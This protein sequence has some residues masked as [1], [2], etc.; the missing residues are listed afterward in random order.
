MAI[1]KRCINCGAPVS[2][3]GYCTECRL[4]DS[5]LRK[6]QN[7]SVYHYN[8]AL[9]KAK[10]R[11]I[12]GA[13][14][15]LRTSLR[16]DKKNIEARNLLGL[17]YYEIGEMVDALNQ[18]VMSINYQARDNVA[19][20]F[21]KN[22]RDDNKQLGEADNI[23][24]M[25]NT[26]LD[27]AESHSFDLAV[28][29]LRRC[30]SVNKH[31]VKA[32]LLLG[33]I[34]YEQGRVGKAKKTISRVLTI[35]RYNPT[36]IRYLREMGE[37]EGDIVRNKDEA[38]EDDLFDED[39]YGVSAATEDGKRPAKKIEPPERP[40]SGESLLNRRYKRLNR[41]K[42]SN[43]YV[44]VGVIIGIA[45]FYLLIVPVKDKNRKR[46][47]SKIESSYSEKLASKNAETDNLNRELDA[48]QA[49][50]DGYKNSE[51]KLNEDKAGLEKKINDLQQLIAEYKEKLPEENTE[52]TTEEGESTEEGDTENTEEA[53]NEKY[54][55]DGIS[56]T[57]VDQMIDNE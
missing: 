2:T 6:A 44:L 13:I 37:S 19:V 39:Y 4:P 28:I 23:A 56:D 21:L 36:A 31:F 46:D 47:I 54:D 25:F 42:M 3:N 20:K 40:K 43:I 33:L 38:D 29:Q 50:I 9:D 49:E 32:Y 26:A 10:I 24:K 5:F 15:S 45:V 41:A 7:T 57:D 48:L 30:V 52:T 11:D 51:A 1:R 35:D 53:Q 8:I 22:V 27:Y 14:D 12:S 16:Y 34:E 55:V 18:W 17:M